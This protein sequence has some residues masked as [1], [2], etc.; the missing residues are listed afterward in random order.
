MT[1]R[2]RPIGVF[3]SGVGG[4]TV[5]KELRRQLPTEST[6]YLGDEARTPYGERDAAEVVRFT[7]EAMGWF[8]RTVEPKLVVLACN[9][10]TAAALEAVREG[11]AIPVIGVI[12]PGAA[13]ALTATA[14][15]AIGVL[16]TRLTVRP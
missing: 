6:V 8:A 4:L 7:R 16:A 9:T 1:G 5:L 3:D 11:S 2:D 14:R 13:A 10:A 12:R 15:R